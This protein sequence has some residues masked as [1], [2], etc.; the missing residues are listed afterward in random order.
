MYIYLPPTTYHLA[1]SIIFY[2]TY[3]VLPI[4]R[5][6][7]DDLDIPQGMEAMAQ[8]NR[9]TDIQ[10]F[11]YTG[12]E[13]IYIYWSILV[14]GLV[15]TR[16]G[17]PHLP[18]NAPCSLTSYALI[19]CHTTDLEKNTYFWLPFQIYQTEFFF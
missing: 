19:H 8:T 11:D 4:P 17:T 10:T 6:R 1:S 16:S 14:L 5:E 18:L 7:L 3:V 15:K 2:F 12:Q 9:I 13:L